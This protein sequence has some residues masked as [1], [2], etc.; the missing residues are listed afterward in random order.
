VVDSSSVREATEDVP[1]L[2][3]PASLG[4]A[5]VI[6]LAATIYLGVEPGPVLG[7]AQRS[8]KQMLQ[9]GTANGGALATRARGGQ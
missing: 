7:Y 5:L 4:A 3:I 9:S 2:P 1:I 6:T 8:A